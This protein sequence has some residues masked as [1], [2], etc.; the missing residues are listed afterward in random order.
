MPRPSGVDVHALDALLA[1]QKQCVSLAQLTQLGL[2]SST[3]AHRTRP[4]RGQWQ[5]ILPGVVL[6]HRGTA[7]EDERVQ[8]ALLYAGRGAVVTGGVALRRCGFRSVRPSETVHLL[9]PDGRRR[10]SS[11]FAL[12]ERTAADVPTEWRDGL[13]CAAP[14]RALVDHVR[15]LRS[16]DEV[17]AVTAEALQRRL[18]S[19]SALVAA[20]YAAQ[21]RRTAAV[22]LAL[23]E[24]LDGVRSV[25]EARARSLILQA[26]LPAP[27][28]NVDLLTEGGKFIASPDGWWEDG[29]VA[30]E[31]NS[32]QHHLD[33][34]AWEATQRRW[35]T[36][37]RLGITVVPVTPA[38]LR[39]D[40]ESF[41]RELAQTLDS[42]R[43]RRIP[44]LV[45]VRRSQAA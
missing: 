45:V 26:R 5:R 18:C 19:S 16:V 29:G 24:V 39:S 14:P 17:R 25:E 38:A 9:V 4:E 1:A 12:L 13:L 11:G 28:W 6:V 21:R 37:A 3:V 23:Q 20:V 22:R 27:Q 41:L 30:L 10:M 43:G 36:M 34:R 2:S 33:P 7:T 31:V 35:R 42:T 32:R 44:G 15:Q 40:R 8:A